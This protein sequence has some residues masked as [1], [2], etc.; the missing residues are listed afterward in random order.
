MNTMQKPVNLEIVKETLRELS[1]L[2]Y[3]NRVWVKGSESEM[4]SMNEA[5]AALF[6][7]SGLDIALEK[8]SVTFSKEIDNEL[9]EI[10]ALLQSNLTA[11]L[12]HRTDELIGSAEW[13]KVCDRAAKVLAELAGNQKKNTSLL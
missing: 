9:R 2:E 7:D 12:T 1:D 13:R 5:A 6:S 11:Q 3:Q 8:N 4:S 10:R